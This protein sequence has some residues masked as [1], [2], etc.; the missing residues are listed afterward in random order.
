LSE[1]GAT[2]SV[3]SAIKQRLESPFTGTILLSFI[4]TNWQIVIL[5]TTGD[6]CAQCRISEVANYWTS[7]PYWM[8]VGIPLLVSALYLG[9]LPFIVAKHEDFQRLLRL[10]KDIKDKIAET[11]A[12]EVVKYKKAMAEL[13]LYLVDGHNKNLEET[14]RL[15]DVYNT[16][17]KSA[18]YDPL[19]RHIESL[20]NTSQ[21]LLKLDFSKVSLVSQM[22]ALNRFQHHLNR[23]VSALSNSKYT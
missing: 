14:K 17:G 18:V 3:H 1:R 21:Q 15:L 16:Q 7:T 12:S 5:L 22:D 2:D 4:L 8:S 9:V 13:L 6:N 11:D 20:E 19:K 23:V 10:K